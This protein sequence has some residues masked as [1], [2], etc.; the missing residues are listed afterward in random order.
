[1][2]PHLLYL[3]ITMFCASLHAYVQRL[4]NAHQTGCNDSFP[5]PGSALHRKEI[6]S[7]ACSLMENGT[8]KYCGHTPFHVCFVLRSGY[9]FL[10]FDMSVPQPIS[11]YTGKTSFRNPNPWV[12]VSSDDVVWLSTHAPNFNLFY[13]DLELYYAVSENFSLARNLEPRVQKR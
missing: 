5:L 6:S 9:P 1:M 8:S 2:T 11:V 3:T 12:F 10:V 7:F 4:C 13:D